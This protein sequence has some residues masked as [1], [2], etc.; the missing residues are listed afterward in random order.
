MAEAVAGKLRGSRIA[1]LSLLFVL[2]SGYGAILYFDNDELLGSTIEQRRSLQ[3][4]KR[5]RQARIL[6]KNGKSPASTEEVP[7]QYIVKPWVGNAA[8][9]VWENLADTKL[10]LLSAQASN[11]EG[12]DYIPRN[13]IDDPNL[14]TRWASSKDDANDQEWVNIDLGGSQSVGAVYIKWHDAYAQDYDIQAAYERP[15][16]RSD[17]DPC[18]DAWIAVDSIDGKS[19]ADAT[20]DYFDGAPQGVRYIRINLTK[21]AAGSD[22]FSI[23][24]IRVYRKKMIVGSTPTNQFCGN[25]VADVTNSL[26]SQYG[27]TLIQSYEN[28]EYFSAS[29]TAGQKDAMFGDDCVFTVEPNYVVKARGITGNNRGAASITKKRLGDSNLGESSEKER[30]LAIPEFNLRDESPPN[31][32]LERISSHGKLNGKY[33][34]FHEGQD[35]HI[36]IFDT[37]IY[38][39]HSE[40][41]TRD[42]EIQRLEEPLIC[43]G[44]STDYASTDHGTHVASIAAGWTHGTGKSATIHPIQV[45]DANGEGS[46]ASLLCG[47]EKLLQDGKDF[48]AAN[49]PKKIRS[50][51]NLSLGV[52]GR[53]DALDKAVK[54]MTDVGYT[55]VIAA[56]NN[57]DNACFY[58]PYHETAITVGAL[59]NAEDGKN[60]KTA[61]SNYGSC[62][63]LWAPGEDIY[64]ASNA[65]EYESVMKSGTS[66]ASA[67]VAGASSLFFEEINTEEYTIEEFA[68]KVKEKVVNKAE[69]AILREIGHGSVNKIVQTTAVRCLQ[70]SNCQPGLTCLRGGECLDL[71]K[72]LKRHSSQY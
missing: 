1:P 51:V 49:A 57:D 19:N 38:P 67:F 50:V 63:D 33:T 41:D 5:D 13:A 6:A 17:G 65:G 35:T 32:G 14:L 27:G 16:C 2:L 25:T 37:G 36:Y 4:T 56:G 39:D 12:K 40:W 64:G 58:S 66:V 70:N 47:M 60:D 52:N 42:P 71:T 69:I 18:P 29:M 23:Y 72:P 15:N 45:L 54:D 62:I 55:V 34:W 22:N 8:T 21:R 68:S 31:W 10:E 20:T 48:N 59:S 61:T 11:V 7:G 46:T 24:Y 53:S 9:D 3:E 28:A 44:T 30:N 43:A 26:L